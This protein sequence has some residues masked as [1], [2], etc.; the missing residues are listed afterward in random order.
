MHVSGQL[1]RHGHLSPR[2]DAVCYEIRTGNIWRTEKISHPLPEI[3][4]FLGLARSLVIILPQLTHIPSWT[5]WDIKDTVEP[6]YNDIGC[7]RHLAYRVRYSVVPINSALLT[8]MLY[9]SV[10][11][12]LIYIFSPFYDVITEFDCMSIVKRLLTLFQFRKVTSS[13]IPIRRQIGLRASFNSD[14]H[15]QISWQMQPLT[16]NRDPIPTFGKFHHGSSSSFINVSLSPLVTQK[17]NVTL[18]DIRSDITTAF[19]L[20]IWF[21]VLLWCEK[22]HTATKVS[23][24]S[25]FLGH[26]TEAGRDQRN[27]AIFTF[28]LDIETCDEINK[29]AMRGPIAQP[30]IVHSHFVCTGD[31]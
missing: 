12:T 10:I 17:R 31:L 4:R 3:E 24:L 26:C 18:N 29:A 21:H 19:C 15:T 22:F 28:T 20:R 27:S 9:S 1:T 5:A 30:S 13:Q 23:R 7:I 14:T 16:Q 6:V 2:K 11:T 8:I 25:S